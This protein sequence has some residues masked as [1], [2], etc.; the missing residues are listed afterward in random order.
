[1]STTLIIGDLHGNIEVIQAAIEQKTTDKVLFIGD[2][3]DSYNR[4]VEDQVNGLRL[5]LDACEAEPTVYTG[6]LG[7]HELS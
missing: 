2:Y 1:M 3:L 5:V 4:S 6:L 7:N